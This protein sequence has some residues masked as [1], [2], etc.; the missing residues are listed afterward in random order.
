MLI[1]CEPTTVQV[2]PFEDSDAVNVDPW[3]TS[4]THRGAEDVLPAE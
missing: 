2:V 1:V 3:R 4:R